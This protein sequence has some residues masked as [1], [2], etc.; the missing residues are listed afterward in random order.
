MSVLENE[1]N[2]ISYVVQLPFF[3][4]TKRNI[5]CLFSIFKF[6]L[7]RINVLLMQ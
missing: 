5:S 4:W 7:S 2:L 3:E 1:W 6:S